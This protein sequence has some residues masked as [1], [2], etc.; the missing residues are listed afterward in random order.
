MPKGVIQKTD[1]TKANEKPNP[2]NKQI[3]P[4]QEVPSP[5]DKGKDFVKAGEKA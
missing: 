4:D 1:F 2:A 5:I 3:T